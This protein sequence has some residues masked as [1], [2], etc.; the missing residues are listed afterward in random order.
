MSVVVFASTTHD[1]YF[2]NTRLPSAVMP[3]LKDDGQAIVYLSIPH[4]EFYEKAAAGL[5]IP[6]SDKLGLPAHHFLPLSGAQPTNNY[7][8]GKGANPAAVAR[9]LGSPTTLYGALGDDVYSHQA[10]ERLVALG[11]DVNMKIIPGMT[12]AHAHIFIQDVNTQLSLI[13]KGTNNLVDQKQV[14]DS[15]LHNDTTLLINTSVPLPQTRALLGRAAQKDVPRVV[16][17]CTKAAGLQHSDFDVVSDIVINRAESAALANH[18]KL[19]FDDECDVSLAT[20]LSEKLNLRCVMTRGGDS[21][22]IAEHGNVI[23]AFPNPV[24]VVDVTG[25]GDAFL[26]AYLAG[27]DQGKD[28]LQTVREAIVVGGLVAAHKGPRFTDFTP[29]VVELHAAAIR[30]T[31]AGFA[32]HGRSRA[33]RAQ[34]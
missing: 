13:Y 18:L 24:K 3:L 32:A 26:G 19:A 8:T 1:F 21:V 5:P 4:K 6:D 31:P 23:E 11:V 34:L 17:N 28:V 29:A 22:L 7:S 15:A 33:L 25:A 2:E 30:A 16:F 12:M 9:V 20:V 27:I 14:P 10:I